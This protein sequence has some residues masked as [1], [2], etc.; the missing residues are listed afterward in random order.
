MTLDNNGGR[1]RINLP[2]PITSNPRTVANIILEVIAEHESVLKEITP[3]IRLTSVDT[4]NLILSATCYVPSPR[5]VDQVS[6][7]LL[8]EILDRLHKAEIT[9]ISPVHISTVNNN[10]QQTTT[11]SQD[12][13]DVFRS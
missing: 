1:V 3:T 4:G 11:V 8:F 5:M 10:L 9:L 13:L 7:D 2:L 12:N 6:S